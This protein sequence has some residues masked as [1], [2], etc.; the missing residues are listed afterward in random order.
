ML[1]RIFTAALTA[2]FTLSIATSTFAH[3][4]LQGSNP[5]DGDILTEPLKEIILEF[6]SKIEQGSFIEITSA[7]GGPIEIE[8]L[9][10]GE[11]TLAGTVAEPFVNGDYAVNWSI[12][13]ADGHPLEGEFSFTV[14]VPVTVA[15]EAVVLEAN[16]SSA[17]TN[18]E[19]ISAEEIEKESSSI[20]V[21]FIALL[22]VIFVSGLV[23]F[24]KRKK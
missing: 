23:F 8:E 11:G 2:L 24:I 18:Q 5:A 21:I 20:T 3:S 6:D 9:I 4:H 17:V 22:A 10:I 14:N 1:K 7:T 13:S 12:I 15:E 16:E 19:T